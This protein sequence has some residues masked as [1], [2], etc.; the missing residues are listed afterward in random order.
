MKVL[1]SESSPAKKTALDFV[2]A[3]KSVFSTEENVTSVS[4]RDLSVSL[5][6]SVFIFGKGCGIIFLGNS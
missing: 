6:K 5:L 3:N 4:G 2:C 1:W